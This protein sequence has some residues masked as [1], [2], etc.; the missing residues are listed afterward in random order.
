MN[1]DDFSNGHCY[2]VWGL[3]QIIDQ[4]QYNKDS[5]GT[6]AT[7]PY[8]CCWTLTTA[9]NTKVTI[10]LIAILQSR[11]NQGDLK[12]VNKGVKKPLSF[13]FLGLLVGPTKRGKTNK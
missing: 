11:Y 10:V 1:R 8:S 7:R 4:V 12:G 6:G 2:N 3:K 13:F 5:Y 9:D